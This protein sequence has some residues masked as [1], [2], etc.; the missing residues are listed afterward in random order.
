MNSPSNQHQQQQQ[1]PLTHNGTLPPNFTLRGANGGNNGL[2]LSP[3]SV[4]SNYSLGGTL[5]RNLG[6]HNNAGLQPVNLNLG[7]RANR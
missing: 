4:L 6:S 2:A 3:T 1:S 7:N 5:S